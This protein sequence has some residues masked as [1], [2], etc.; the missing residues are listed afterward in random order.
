MTTHPRSLLIIIVTAAM[1]PP[2][3]QKLRKAS[4]SGSRLRVLHHHSGSVETSSQQDS[5]ASVDGTGETRVEIFSV[6]R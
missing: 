2:A 4:P 6:T 1:V 3:L 5:L